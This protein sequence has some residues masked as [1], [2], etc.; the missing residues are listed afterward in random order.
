MAQEA[1]RGLL[2]DLEGVLYNADQLIPGALEAM[3]WVQEHRIPHL[4]VTNTTSRSRAVLVEK[5]TSF[6]LVASESEILTPAVAAEWLRGHHAQ[7][8]ALFARPSTD[9]EFADLTCLPEE[10]EEVLLLS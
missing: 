2:F 6:G 5:L 4:F 3:H 7:E 8:L 1:L 9:R 10:A